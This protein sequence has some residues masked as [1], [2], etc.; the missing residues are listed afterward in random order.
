MNTDW[1]TD[2]QAGRIIIKEILSS[3]NVDFALSLSRPHAIQVIKTF[4]EFLKLTEFID[5]RLQWN[6]NIGG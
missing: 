6:D 2:R 5:N 1:L 3:F 4:W